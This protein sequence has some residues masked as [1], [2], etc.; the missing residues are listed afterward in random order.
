MGREERKPEYERKKKI[1]TRRKEKQKGR[2]KR[3]KKEREER[4]RK[5]E[6]EG[7]SHSEQRANPDGKEL[8]TMLQEVGFLLLRFI[9]RPGAV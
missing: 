9:S 8:R 1:E 2:R 7:V 3:R 4:E 6:K 5:K